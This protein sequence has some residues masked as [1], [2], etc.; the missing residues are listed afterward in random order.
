M[1]LKARLI[2]TIDVADELGEC[3]LWRESDS[4]VW[5]TDIEQRRIHRL[6][7]PSLRLETTRTP[8]RL[9]SFA[10]LYGTDATLLAAFDR[11]WARFT[12]SSGEVA[13]LDQPEELGGRVRLNDGRAD[14]QGRFWTGSMLEG[15]LEPGRRPPGML[16]RLDAR[17]R[18]AAVLAGVHVSNGLCWSLSGERMYFADSSRREIYA[19]EYDPLAGAPGRWSSFARLTDGSPDG[20]VTDAD[21][22]IWTAV[23]DAGY[24]QAFDGDGSPVARVAIEG[25]RPTCPVF[26]GPKRNLLFVSSARVGL[27]DVTLRSHPLSGSLFVFETNVAGAPIHRAHLR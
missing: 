12:P 22:R 11:G 24:V 14:A 2:E 26:G 16:Y 1:S 21:D 8:E 4:S 19:A 20:T 27:S 10:F 23:W 25:P 15:T 3:V 17:G 5:W 13:W 6:A 7:W 18:A 9:C